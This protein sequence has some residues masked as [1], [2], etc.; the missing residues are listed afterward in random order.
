MS[1]N[2]NKFL[3]IA[4]LI[5]SQNSKCQNWMLDL[6]PGIKFFSLNYVANK[7]VVNNSEL[8]Q[9]QCNA[10][11]KIKS[12]ILEPELF[13]DLY[14]INPKW[15]IGFGITNFN[16]KN[17]IRVS[18]L[19]TS[20][21]LDSSNSIIYNEHIIKTVEL[22]F[23]QFS[24]TITRTFRITP[25]LDRIILNKLILG[26]GVNKSSMYNPRYNEKM[27]YSS[28]LD[29]NQGYITTLE[30]N[31]N[32]LGGNYSPFIQL[33]YELVIMN[34]KNDSGRLNL[35]FSYVQGFQNQ[36]KFR[37][38]SNTITGANLNVESVCNISGFRFGISKTLSFTKKDL[39]K[40]IFESNLFR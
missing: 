4:F 19:G 34:K 11:E 39:D 15:Q 6:K 32:K 24:G 9:Y 12:F 16:F 21:F 17:K 8:N 37:L 3:I 23:A 5:I 31:K 29:N 18:S 38:E 22:Q 40:G 25:F 27:Y 7:G 26:V 36:Y 20:A 13:V 35:T 33:K 30:Y 14:R 1:R 10:N 28:L 2:M